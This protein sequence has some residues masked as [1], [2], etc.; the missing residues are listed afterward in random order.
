MR[1]YQKYLDSEDKEFR[2]YT[3]ERMGVLKEI[4]HF[5]VKMTQTNAILEYLARKNNLEPETEEAKMNLGMIR[6]VLADLKNHSV[7]FCMHPAHRAAVS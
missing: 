5:Q 7:G 4:I 2:N 1:W 3:Q 6:D